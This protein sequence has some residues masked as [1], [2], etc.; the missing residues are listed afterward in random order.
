M[1]DFYRDYEITFDTL[2][3]IREERC[4]DFVKKG[5]KWFMD[6]DPESQYSVDDGLLEAI[7]KCLAVLYDKLND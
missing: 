7:D 5:Y 4:E 6:L 2:K 3:K 1:N